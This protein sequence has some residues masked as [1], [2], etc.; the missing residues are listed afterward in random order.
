MSTEEDK[1]DRAKRSHAQEESSGAADAPT[2]QTRQV[3][4][5]NASRQAWLPAALLVGVAYF[6]VGWA[7]ALPTNDVV[8][9]RLSAWVVSGCS[10]AAHI[11]YEH[12]RVGSS[13][14][15]GA[16][17]IAV[18]VMIGAIL[19]AVAGMLH[20]LLNTSMIGLTWLLAIVVWPAVT[21]IPAFVGALVAG[22]VLARLPR[23]TDAR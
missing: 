6:L 14:L 9:W 23:S 12:Y 18:A 5:M 2:R 7:F 20:S 21:A 22:V 16:S 3:A 1:G 11:A 13:P 4:H 19:L 8:F 15:V 17:H 10:Y